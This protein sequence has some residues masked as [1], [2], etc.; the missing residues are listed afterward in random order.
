MSLITR[1]PACQTLFR[2]VPDQLR[3]SEGWVRCGQC[4]EVFDAS[5]HLQDE[6]QWLATPHAQ[7]APHADSPVA[8]ERLSGEKPG[9]APKLL[10]EAAP[11]GANAPPT[12]ARSVSF[13]DAGENT[14]QDDSSEAGGRAALTF[15]VE[16]VT[17]ASYL[18]VHEPAP[19]P[20]LL[21]EPVLDIHHAIDPILADNERREVLTAPLSSEATAPHADPQPLADLRADTDSMLVDEAATAKAAAPSASDP[22]LS[23]MRRS[24]PHSPW[25]CPLVRVLL[26]ATCLLLLGALGL[27]VL[28]H[29]RNY[30]AAIKPGLKPWVKQVCV[31]FDCRVEPLRQIESVVIDSSALTRIK[32]DLYRLDLTITNHAP[33]AVAM[34]W[35]ELSVT[36]TLDQALLRRVLKPEDLGVSAETLA[37]A[38]EIQGS[39]ILVITPNGGAER[40]TG[41]RLLAFYP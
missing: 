21:V 33:L 13:R 27:Q 15:S 28:V 3:V 36:D 35:I 40:M 37:A 4:D 30:L 5:A 8:P 34:P 1:C 32:G 31:W 11:S 23:F 19:A 20:E 38:S 12:A 17:D 29:E 10:S 9:A 18:M 7:T 24:R 39:L 14:H 2:V 6:S 16:P 22:A 41:Y 25:R 26:L